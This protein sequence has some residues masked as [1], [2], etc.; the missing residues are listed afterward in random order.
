[1]QQKSALIALGRTLALS[2]TACA[3]EA[4]ELEALRG[5]NEALRQQITALTEER[6]APVP[7]SMPSPVANPN[8]AFLSL[9]PMTEENAGARQAFAAALEQVVREQIMPDGSDCSGDGY[10][11]MEN[12]QFAVC[13]V[14]GDGEEELILLYTTASTAGHRGFVCSWEEATGA[15]D[16]QLDAYPL[17]TFYESG[18][19]QVGWS[20][21]QGKGGAFW[22][23]D[24]YRY[25]SFLDTYVN[26]G[27]VDA[28]DES[29][30]VEGYPS[31]VDQ[32][33]SGFV[34]YI[35]TDGYF[36]WEDPLDA[37]VYEAWRYPYV[38]NGREVQPEYLSLTEENIQRILA[39]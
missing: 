24:L 20:H 14:D 27:A 2:L 9:A 26:V 8:P 22:P 39:F 1:M 13:D 16:I 15:L 30:P 11:S 32:S 34:Y 25:D 4:G 7:S 33:E 29:L 23:Y 3:G 38:R 35:E 17:F 21:N 12:N 37:A 31:E 28:W 36:D 6:N 10:P 18:A 5:E 19:V